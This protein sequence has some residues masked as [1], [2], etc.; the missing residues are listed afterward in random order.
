MM[1][2]TLVVL[3]SASLG[4]LAMR[5]S[6]RRAALWAALLFA[7]LYFREIFW[8]M[9]QN[10]GVQMLPMTLAI[11]AAYKAGDFPAGSRRAL[12]WTALAGVC[13]GIVFWFKYPFALFGM[14]LALAHIIRRGRIPFGIVVREALAYIFGVALVILAVIGVMVVMGWFHEWTLHLQTVLELPKGGELL[15]TLEGVTYQFARQ[16]KFWWW[17]LPLLVLWGLYVVNSLAT[18]ARERRYGTDTLAFRPSPDPLAQPFRWREWGLIV[19]PMLGA[20][21][22]IFSQGKGYEYHWLPLLPGLIIVS[23]DALERLL[24]WSAGRFQVR[25]K[26]LS[27]NTLAAMTTMSLLVLLGLGTWLPSWR[28]MTGQ[29]TKAEYYAAFNYSG[30]RYS[31]QESLE[32]ADYLAAHTNRDDTLFI[33]GMRPEVYLYSRLRPATRFIMH[34]PLA[35]S[36]ALP[37]WQT[38]ALERLRANPP[39]YMLV[40]TKDSISF[41]TGYHG[42]SL[43][44]LQKSTP[45]NDWLR[46]AYAPE[47]TI[48]NFQVWAYQG[49]S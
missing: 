22:A 9:A 18:L 24:S 17:I 37:E 21:A 10:D 7:V 23:A 30:E 15:P 29:E 45:L 16:F 34:Y 6:G 12:A 49:E 1:D 14:G 4:Y 26:A 3:M 42:D 28:Y 27:Y 41:V 25:G 5:L 19:L 38:E 44:L 36:W 48:G 47:T 20:V 2:I 31:A 40:L 13:C 46:S 39:A 8:T 32:V 33:W 11:I 35:S 43:K